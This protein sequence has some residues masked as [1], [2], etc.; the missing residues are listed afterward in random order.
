MANGILYL[1][2][3]GVAGGV[4]GDGVTVCGDEDEVP[5]ILCC[6]NPRARSN[7]LLHARVQPSTHTCFGDATASIR[8]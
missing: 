4:G 5:P 7:F 6:V 3:V 1:H 2:Y 8:M